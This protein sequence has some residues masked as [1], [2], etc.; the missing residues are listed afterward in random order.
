MKE[1]EH[2]SGV[3]SAQPK[4]P[5]TVYICLDEVTECNRYIDRPET[6]TLTMGYLLS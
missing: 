5:T 4:C 6:T 3:N 1:N 2:C